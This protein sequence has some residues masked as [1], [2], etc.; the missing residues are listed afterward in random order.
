MSSNVSK[1]NTHDGKVK[2]QLAA[3]SNY[4]VTWGF[5]LMVGERI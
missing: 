1:L 5:L 4:L 3:G 2:R